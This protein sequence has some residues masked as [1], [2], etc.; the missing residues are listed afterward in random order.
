MRTLLILIILVNSIISANA[1]KANNF[2][3]KFN[4]KNIVSK[5]AIPETNAIECTYS[6]ASLKSKNAL[7]ITINEKQ[8]KA[9]WHR[10]FKISDENEM[11]ILNSEQKTTSGVFGIS[12]VLPSDYKGTSIK[13]T[14]ML[15]PNDRNAAATMR[16]RSYPLVNITIK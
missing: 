8:P 2:S 15:V 16:L 4:E 7:L 11:E 14:T 10:E 12:L 9:D 1:Q 3:M 6:K 13:I 5:K